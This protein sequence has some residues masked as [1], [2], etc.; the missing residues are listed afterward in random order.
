LIKTKNKCKI[1]DRIKNEKFVLDTN[2]KEINRRIKI[3]TKQISHKKF[4]NK[5]EFLSSSEF[6]NNKLLVD[7][8]G[9]LLRKK[10]QKLGNQIC[11]KGA[12]QKSTIASRREWFGYQ[13]KQ[14]R[15]YA[16]IESLKNTLEE[17]STNFDINL[18]KH[19]IKA[20][21]NRLPTADERIE[22]YQSRFRSSK[23]MPKLGSS[24]KS[25]GTC[26]KSRKLNRFVK[27]F[28]HKKNLGRL[29][30]FEKFSFRSLE[31][32]DTGLNNQLSM[33]RGKAPASSMNVTDFWD[34]KNT[35]KAV[36]STNYFLDK[37]AIKRYT[38]LSS[39]Y[40]GQNLNTNELFKKRSK[41]RAKKIR[42]NELKF[43]KKKKVKINEE[44]VKQFNYKKNGGLVVEKKLEPEMYLQEKRRQKIVDMLEI[45]KRMEERANGL[46]KRKIKED[47]YPCK[48]L[49]QN[50]EILSIDE[51]VDARRFPLIR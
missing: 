27:D 44:K 51:E 38:Y 33:L 3:F 45:Q 8:Q 2:T 34:E 16:N 25:K 42:K 6:I 32:S 36:N 9:K 48:S 15:K 21:A 31:R 13:T 47:F 30:T 22:L 11:R 20:I 4:R 24:K 17:M 18:N 43:S 35:I 50:F 7:A 12:K 41:T 1:R 23:S 37:K 40:Q 14:S 49:Y 39:F 28:F 19:R 46:E 5:E 29:K 10:K 26:L